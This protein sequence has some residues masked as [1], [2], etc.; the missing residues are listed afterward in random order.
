MNIERLGQSQT[1][2]VTTARTSGPAEP[3]ARTAVRTTGLVPHDMVSVSAQ[4]RDVQR[5]AEAAQAVPDIRVELVEDLRRRIA[6]GAYH[7]PAD[8]LADL[9]LGH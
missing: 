2:G 4:A 6:A 1:Q 3:T 9:L 7:V 8:V 5:A